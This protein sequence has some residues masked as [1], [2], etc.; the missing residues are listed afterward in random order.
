MK[1]SLLSTIGIYGS[2]ELWLSVSLATVLKRNLGFFLF[3]FIKEPSYTFKDY[4]ARLNK[5][6]PVY[7]QV[8]AMFA[9]ICG[10][11]FYTMELTSFVL[12]FSF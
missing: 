7:F 6:L 2:V 12:L 11:R 5:T 8:F 10:F 9:L 1:L 3:S 4:L